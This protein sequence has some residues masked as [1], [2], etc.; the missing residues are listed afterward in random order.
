[1]V[2]LIFT[3]IVVA[4]VMGVIQKIVPLDGTLRLIING[5]IALVALVWIFRFMGY[6]VG[7]F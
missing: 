5:L 1:M 4:I 2:Q 3:L 6:N 7:H